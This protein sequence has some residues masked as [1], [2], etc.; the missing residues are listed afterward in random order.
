MALTVVVALAA[1]GWVAVT[2]PENRWAVAVAVPVLVVF[3]VVLLARSTWIDPASGVLVR[4]VVWVWKRRVSLATASDISLVN[5]RGGIL[6]LGVRGQGH[7][8][9]TYI[10]ILQLG[11]GGARSQSPEFLG[12]VA[13]QIEHFA[14]QATRTVATPL[15]KQA[16][17]I[18]A[19]GN[20]AES[21]LAPLISHSMMNA[22]K[23]GGAAGGGSSLL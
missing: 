15:R 3:F 17:F 19:G 8:M 1:V 10:P 22:A 5:N 2:Q 9:R 11:D 21:P 20:P 18:A 13:G 14:P 6:L 23:A 4:R 7:R 16:D 12:L